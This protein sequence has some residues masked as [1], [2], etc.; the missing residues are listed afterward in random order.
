MK[1]RL[2]SLSWMG[3]LA[4][5]NAP[6]L[7]GK[8][9]QE[10]GAPWHPVVDGVGAIEAEAPDEIVSDPSSP[11]HAWVTQS[12]PS[13]GFFSAATGGKY[14]QALDDTGAAQGALPPLVKYRFR[15][16]DA[17]NY[18]AYVRGS[19][20]DQ[21]GNSCYIQ[22]ANSAGTLLTSAAPALAGNGTWAWAATSAQNLSAGV[23]TVQLAMREDGTAVDKVVLQRADL[24]A[25]TGA[26]P[27]IPNEVL[28]M[29][30]T[31][32]G[33]SMPPIV[34]QYD[35]SAGTGFSWDAMKNAEHD[36]TSPREGLRDAVVLLRDALEQMTSHAPMI[37]NTADLSS[38]T[39]ILLTTLA[40]APTFIQNNPDVIAA[41]A[42][43]PGDANEAYYLLTEPTRVWI[44]ASRLEGLVT[45]VPDLLESVG[46]TVLGMGPNW[47]HAPNKQSG[48]ELS[49][50]KAG[51]PGYLFRYIWPSSGQS[52]GQG[53]ISEDN[54]VKPTAPDESVE[55][56]YH[57][58]L[59]GARMRT[60]STKLNLGHALQSYHSQVINLIR[61]TQTAQGFLAPTGVGPLASR[62]SPTV[63]GSLWVDTDDTDAYFVK[64][65]AWVKST[66]LMPASIDLSVAGVRQLVLQKMLTVS[67][68]A[69][70]TNPDD[71]Y[72]FPAD[73]EDGSGYTQLALAALP[74]WYP[75]Y[76]SQNGDA[77]GDP[78]VMAGFKGFALPAH[79][80]ETW[81]A[82]AA[83]DVVFA[84]RD[85]LL[86]EYDK[87]IDARPNPADRVTST[88]KSKKALIR[89][90]GLSYNYF[91]V[92][93]NFNVD[94]RMRIAIAGF[95]K[96]RARGEWL[97]Y[98]SEAIM[99]DAIAHL[100]PQGLPSLNWIVSG[101]GQSD[102]Y[103][104]SS[105]MAAPSGS[106]I[107]MAKKLRDYFASA[108]VRGL[109]AESDLNFGRLG[110]DYYMMAKVMWNPSLTDAQLLEA[111]EDY[112]RK[113]Y[114]QAAFA[115]M[116]EY[117]LAA[118]SGTNPVIGQ[119]LYARCVRLLG[120]ADALIL[121]GTPEQARLDDLKTHWYHYYF[122]D[123]DTIDAPTPAFR[124]FVWKA[125]MAYQ[126]ALRFDI[127]ESGIAPANSNF[128]PDLAVPEWISSPL[129]YT[130]SETAVW[131]DLVSNRWHEVAV[132]NFADPGRTLV[133]STPTA[134]VDL[135]D[136]VA[137]EEF[138]SAPAT[139][140][141][142]FNFVKARNA[143]RPTTIALAEGE[144]I[145]FQMFWPGAPAGVFWG[146]SRYDTDQKLW[147]PI[148]DVQSN[149]TQ[150]YAITLPDLTTR[151]VLRV[152]TQAPRPGVY[153]FETQGVANSA[154]LADLAWDATVGAAGTP[155]T[156]LGGRLT[157]NYAL[158]DFHH[159]YYV[160]IPKGT[161]TFDFEALAPNGARDVQFYKRAPTSGS[162]IDHMVPFGA[163][164]P[165]HDQGTH[166]IAV[167]SGCDG[168]I[169][170]VFKRPVPYLYSVPMLW[171]KS[172]SQ[173]LV[174]RQIA[175]ADGLHVV[176]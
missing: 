66:G 112:L 123:T 75:T 6:E 150:S 167:P 7:V 37:Q 9:S 171:A 152:D 127:R 33:F 77:L 175:V 5:S 1:W 12:A 65:G 84:F 98:R 18:I 41:L 140:T 13:S 44:V 53:T 166:R 148:I 35:S 10:L 71:V 29:W 94:P 21:G 104:T 81:N 40:G 155:G 105:V 28:T 96:Q 92:V 106:P 128:R 109:S 144:H 164:V 32:P 8:Q 19:G 174:P 58:W 101:A 141:Y 132:T 73:P 22:L 97:Y 154:V 43:A 78:W 130:P 116:W 24:P 110:P 88:G 158:G 163:A 122:V 79:T 118:W 134:S 173:L 107:A 46:Y 2:F 138:G 57:R 80:N 149:V 16:T 60:Y 161:T 146:M 76:R 135:E 99:A 114:G 67:D 63:E 42:G 108:N 62:P 172:P 102:F 4:C 83:T 170:R 39:G 15:I 31:A 139:D 45:A 64:G 48:L 69:F 115:K 59:I 54:P 121:A 17:G 145:G 137:V 143:P 70:A 50:R 85:W 103:L 91:D 55:A 119:S 52:G 93:P 157:Y 74:S 86:R 156:T 159:Y 34:L 153:R 61:S 26:G 11:P 124:E 3:L 14:I 113:A 82:L 27:D 162:A 168:A 147:E 133:D 47:A 117:Y 90:D 38:A 126:V 72:G 129:H 20:P 51:R 136:L 87:A 169:A 176:Q 165:A 68:T 111:L 120:E 100:L 131:W 49:V 23:Y 142:A 160:Y 25:P 30:S 89:V 56:S 36:W 125:Q 151:H 95:G